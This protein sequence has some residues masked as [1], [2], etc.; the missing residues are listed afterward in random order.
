MSETVL[1]YTPGFIENPNEMF[2]SLKTNLQWERRKDAPRCEYYCNDFDRPYTYGRDRGRRIYYPQ[3]W[4]QTI[5]SVRQKLETLTGSKFEV[6]F[7][8]MYL[9]QNDHFGWH[10]DDSPEIDDARPIAIVSFGV[11]RE[12]WFRRNTPDSENS[13]GKMSGV[14]KLKLENGSVCVMHPGMQDNWQHRIP[15]ASF[16]CG[17]RISLTFRGYVDETR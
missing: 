7:L 13:P 14:K 6:C 10:A 15:K 16:K 11:E 2:E 3:P 4:N 1:T 5:L 17:E 9:N 8:N 12:I